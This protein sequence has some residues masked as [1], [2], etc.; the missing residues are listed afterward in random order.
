MKVAVGLIF[1]DHQ[2]L[3]IT[4]RPLDAPHGGFWEFPGGK[5]D[6]NE[7]P[8]QALIRE[9]KEE[10]NLDVK[11]YHY[12]GRIHHDYPKHSVC[13]LIFKVTRYSGIPRC[14]E[15]Q[16][17]MKWTHKDEL[18]DKNFP[19]ANHQIIQLLNRAS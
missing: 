19:E 10:V 13:L 9:I 3:L 4:Q 12:L 8:E 15:G 16:L 14:N 2:R 1:D 17:D 18:S 7:T 6:E 5:L 11:E